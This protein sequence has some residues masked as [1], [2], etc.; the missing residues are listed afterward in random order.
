VLDGQHQLVGND[1][2]A[3]LDEDVQG[4]GDGPLQAVLDGGDPLVGQAAVDGG[5]QGS[6]AGDG[7]VLRLRVVA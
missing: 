6:D 1:Q 3:V 4:L 2:L 7:Q 5:G